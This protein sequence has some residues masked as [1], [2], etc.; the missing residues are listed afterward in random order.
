MLILLFS[1]QVTLS[2]ARHSA[3]NSRLWDASSAMHRLSLSLV[4]RL[5]SQIARDSLGHDA[6]FYT[7]RTE[8]DFTKHGAKATH[9]AV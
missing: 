1:V 6:L 2:N 7:P 8:Y 4:T 5:Y 3:P 9:R